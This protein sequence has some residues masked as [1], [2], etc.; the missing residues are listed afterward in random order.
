MPNKIKS[1]STEVVNK[2]AAGEI[3]SR[4][5]SVVKE[6]MENSLDAGATQILV[7][8]KGGG[9]GLIRVTDNG[10]GISRQDLPLVFHRYATSK[11][12]RAEDLE[13]I[14][15]LGFRGEAVPSIAAV[16]KIKLF[17]KTKGSLA[18][19]QII[20]VGGKEE[21]IK[22]AGCP[23]GTQIDVEELFFNTP[24][25][26]KFLKSNTTE[27]DHI[28][29][30]VESMALSFYE[31]AFKLISEGKELINVPR[32]KNPADRL[33]ALY[34][35]QFFSRLKSLSFSNNFL[36]VRGFISPP[37]STFSNRN[38]QLIFVNNRFIGSRLLSHA[39]Y[40]AYLN[41]IPPKRY[42]AIF[43]FIRI[44][45]SLIDVNVHPAKSEIRFINEQA[46]HSLLAEEIKKSLQRGEFS[47]NVKYQPLP[48]QF[49]QRERG[50]KE[51]IADYMTKPNKTFRSSVDR[52]NFFANI[53][54][55]N[56]SK[57]DLSQPKKF[58]YSNSKE[59]K[60]GLLI[61]I[62]IQPLAQMSNKYILAQKGRN[63]L[64]ID[65]HAAS[66]RIVYEQFKEEISK[67]AVSIQGLLIPFTIELSPSQSVVVKKNVTYLN[68]IGFQIEEFGANDFK[69]KGIPALLG[70]KNNKQIIQDV[71]DRLLELGTVKKEI[72]LTDEITD[73]I[74][75]TACHTAIRAKDSLGSRE[76]EKL[77]EDL[78]RTKNPFTCP[79]GRPIIIEIT[80]EEL[81]RKFKRI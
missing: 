75:R 41:I 55:Q 63:L 57:Q 29:K 44:E 79:H 73:R 48:N 21:A 38:R 68:K 26:R 59:E 58:V 9:K 28:S 42:P 46:I 18:G 54:K 71:L 14:T 2:I 25:R 36:S 7:E 64:V 65:Q 10:E 66:E 24:A 8:I 69:V 39:I 40:S 56:L 60:E 70:D 81:D 76:I 43:L 27:I 33:V 61:D 17:T 45:P 50:I 22:E 1:L 53:N 52:K 15:S 77:V 35:N 3:V 80:E 34:G 32:V 5:A 31:V 13:K 20:S 51:C 30:I 23:E 37:S 19:N 49:N 62:Q 72:E 4:P 47:A 6:L 74:I 67:E 78:K 16:S 12:T 11:I